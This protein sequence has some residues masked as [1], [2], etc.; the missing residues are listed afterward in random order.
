MYLSFASECQQKL[1]VSGFS[2]AGFQRTPVRYA[3]TVSIASE[4]ELTS[5]L[6]NS[7]LT[8]ACKKCFLLFSQERTSTRVRFCLACG[9]WRVAPHFTGDSRTDLPL[10]S[11][12][13]ISFS[14]DE[15][16]YW[17]QL[18]NHAHIWLAQRVTGLIGFGFGECLVGIFDRRDDKFCF[19]TD[20][21]RR[22]G[23]EVG[24]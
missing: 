12:F 17:L 16:S 24:S 22:D 20:A 10:E 2:F 13:G 21:R 7:E 18:E 11:D 8:N 9:F 23:A 15:I 14:F 3:I 1:R 19:D 6:Q 5:L 4:Q